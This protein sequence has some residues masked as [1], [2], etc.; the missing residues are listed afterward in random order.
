MSKFT[1]IV[2]DEDKKELRI[3]N[4]GKFVRSSSGAIEEFEIEFNKYLPNDGKTY[5]MKFFFN[6]V[7]ND[8]ESIV[9]YPS[10]AFAPFGGIFLIFNT[11]KH[12]LEQTPYKITCGTENQIVYL[13]FSN[14][15]LH[16]FLKYAD[17][18]LK[19][20]NYDRVINS[21]DNSGLRDFHIITFI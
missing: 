1:N 4:L 16:N 12:D 18:Q 6:S 13:T 10:G 11:D 14:F 21:N 2:Y 7:K 8:V 20:T 17:I 9:C 15:N 5:Y 3:N 19:K